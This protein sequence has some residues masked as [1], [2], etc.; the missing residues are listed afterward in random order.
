MGDKFKIKKKIIKQLDQLPKSK[1]GKVFKYI[2]SLEGKEKSKKDI[3]AFAGSWKN[4]DP[5]LFEEFTTRLQDRRTK[6][7]GRRIL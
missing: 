2:E 1:L 4:I 5:E 6:T 7:N 3:L